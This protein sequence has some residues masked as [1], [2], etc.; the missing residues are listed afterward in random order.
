[1]IRVEGGTERAEAPSTA[2]PRWRSLARS[3]SGP[4][5]IVV[6]VLVVLRDLAFRGMITDQHID[7]L[8]FWLP[9]H[10]FLGE[11]L[12]AGTIPTWNPHVMAGLPFAADPQSGWMYLPAMALHA[13]LPCGA[14]VGL[15]IVLQP[16]VAGLSLY[17]FL[18]TEGLSRPS[19][20]V[21]GLALSLG[22]AGSTMVV[23]LPIV[24]SVAWTAVLLA[25]ASKFLRA[26][27]WSGRV[28]WGLAVA[29]GWGQLAAAHLS[30]GLVIGTTIV[31]VYAAVRTVVD[32]R[33]G[34][35]RPGEAVLGAV[36][37]LVLLFP[38]NLAF[39]LPRLGYLPDATLGL[40]YEGLDR[41]ASGLAGSTPEAFEAG[42]AAGASWPLRLATSPGAYL[43]A[44]VLL[45]GFAGWWARRLRSL[46]AAFSALG[47][48]FYLASLEVVAR[49]VTPVARA[50]PLGDF[51]LHEPTRFRVGLF[52]ILP[53]LGSL[54][55]ESWLRRSSGRLGMVLLGLLVWGGLLVVLPVEGARLLLPG[56]AAVVVMVAL[57]ATA[58]KAAL[59]ALLP[60]LLALELV[61]N[62]LVGQ[63][64]RR[65]VRPDPEV[66]GEG[67]G[68]PFVNLLRPELPTGDYLR[69]GRIARALR[70]D[71]EAGRFVTI[72]PRPRRFR[73]S[74]YLS[75]WEPEDRGLLNNQRAILF[76]LEDAQG[77]NPIQPLPYWMFVRH[78]RPPG[79]RH[80]RGILRDPSPTELDL[81]QVGWINGPADASPGEETTL[82]VLEGRWALYRRPSAPRAT[83]VHA[84]RVEAGEFGALKVVADERFDPAELVVLDRDPGLR[85]TDGDVAPGGARYEMLGPSEA[86]IEVSS[87]APAV[88]LIRNTH[89]PAWEA[90][91]DG[92]RADVLRANFF[93]QAVVVPVG[94]SVVS[95]RFRDPNVGRG[96][97]GSAAILLLLVG[98]TMVLR[99][100]ERR[101][102]PPPENG[103]EG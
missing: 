68:V 43:G 83:V 9:T 91:V 63:A 35:R 28:G 45:L 14:A 12:A 21:G 22:M 96:L 46:T 84:W 70:S 92:R 66:L 11:N 55:M 65:E 94:E 2:D 99:A 41:L 20:T 73:I 15:F 60:G 23:S 29:V 31:L 42:P 40:G 10:C 97:A 1:V 77:Y 76:G 27:A 62:G 33:E 89:H 32:V 50:L 57:W 44:V 38:V 47:L 81:L 85:T 102:A 49:A 30:H 95:L 64:E 19:A 72:P 54:G 71:P 56:V 51:Y 75:Y 69:E 58:R 67:W 90:T 93:L 16:I 34:R 86:R 7:L 18:R 8:S 80:N 5:L 59:A 48:L 24:G 17:W 88:L 53:V 3:L 61:A 25:L 26:R 39:F 87:P 82:E 37:L 101:G 78:G 13:L 6:S 74:G 36:L 4:L 100:R 98:G 103:E 79:L 52:L